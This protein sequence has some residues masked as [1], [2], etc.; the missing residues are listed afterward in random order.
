M[1]APVLLLTRPAADSR[2]FAQG[3]AGWHVVIAPVLE[4]VAV[5]HDGARLAGAEVLVFTSAHAVP[6]AG[7]GRGR[8]AFCVGPRT[9]AVARAAGFAVTEGPGD[10]A[11]LRPML[12]GVGGAVHPHGAHLAADLGVPG[13]VVY[14][15]R[16]VALTAQARALL[17]TRGAQV[18]APLFSPRSAALLAAQARD[19]AAEIWIAAISPAARRA[20]DAP[21]AGVVE[22]AR[23]DAAG[24]RDAILD[25]VSKEH[26]GPGAG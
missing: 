14:D 13:I 12:Q 3:F 19:V 6:A 23:P 22:A 21:H 26:L 25:L 20:Y 8:A 5:P 24:L 4:I 1:P 18:I 9:A 17:A 15:Q 7:P 2:R 10:A 16:A 11:G